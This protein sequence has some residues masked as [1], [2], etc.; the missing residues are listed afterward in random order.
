MENRVLAYQR[1][2]EIYIFKPNKPMVDFLPWFDEPCE[3]VP[4]SE[5]ICT[6][7]H[8]FFNCKDDEAVSVT[9]EI[10]LTHYLADRTLNQ[11]KNFQL[12]PQTLS[13]VSP[14]PHQ[15]AEGNEKRRQKSCGSLNILWNQATPQHLL[16]M[17]TDVHFLGPIGR[18]SN[19]IMQGGREIY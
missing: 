12:K 8:F 6:I 5:L 1:L 14:P 15:P 19:S 16:H 17:L 7:L 18:K 9:A 4:L 3:T 2:R 13:V 10:L 11:A